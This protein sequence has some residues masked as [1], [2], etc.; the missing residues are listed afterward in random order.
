MRWT[1]NFF[2]FIFFLLLTGWGGRAAVRECEHV[3]GGSLVD[4]TRSMFSHF[5]LD[6]FT[7]G[8]FKCFFPSLAN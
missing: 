8:N 3:G 4:S 6:G 1:C 7:L 5:W 2:N